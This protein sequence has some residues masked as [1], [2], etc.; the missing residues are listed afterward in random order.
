MFVDVTVLGD[1]NGVKKEAYNILKIYRPYNINSVQVEC[2]SKSDTS[3]TRGTRNHLNISQAIPERHTGKSRN[4]GTIK[5]K[6]V[7]GTEHIIRKVLI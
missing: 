7:L 5:K 2:E 4:Q 1:R 3:Y 6:A